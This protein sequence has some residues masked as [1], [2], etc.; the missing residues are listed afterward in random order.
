MLKLLNVKTIQR[1]EL[2]KPSTNDDNNKYEAK[3]TIWYD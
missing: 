3:E 1:I 2:K